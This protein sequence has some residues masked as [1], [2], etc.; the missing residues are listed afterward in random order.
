MERLAGGSHIEYLS[1]LQVFTRERD[2]LETAL[3]G[4]SHL[5]GASLKNMVG[6]LLVITIHLIPD[7]SFAMCKVQ[8]LV[9]GRTVEKQRMI[10]HRT[11]VER[12]QLHFAGLRQ[13]PVFGI[14]GKPRVVGLTHLKNIVAVG[15]YLHWSGEL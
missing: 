1:V 8:H 13:S 15:L 4:V 10:T 11:S 2:V 5:K 7:V 9:A 12:C 6:N 3:H 14:D